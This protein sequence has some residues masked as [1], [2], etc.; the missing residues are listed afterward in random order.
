M[1]QVRHCPQR[2][3]SKPGKARGYHPCLANRLGI[4]LALPDE[5]PGTAGEGSRGPRGLNKA[6]RW[7]FIGEEAFIL[8]LGKDGRDTQ[9][10]VVLCWETGRAPSHGERERK[11]RDED[12]AT[13]GFKERTVT[14]NQGVQRKRLCLLVNHV[15]HRKVSDLQFV[16]P[17]LNSL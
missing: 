4:R 12:R 8:F 15:S 14:S 9:L 16:N 17:I 13:R 7:D 1:S 11:G 6:K 5:K 2:R 3:H 10:D